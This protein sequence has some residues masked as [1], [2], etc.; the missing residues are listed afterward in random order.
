MALSL[1]RENT[2]GA[3]ETQKAQRNI[4]DSFALFVFL[5]LRFL[6]SSAD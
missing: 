4:I 3:K 2:R 1:D 6:C 5:L